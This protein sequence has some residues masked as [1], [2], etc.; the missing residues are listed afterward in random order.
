[1]TNMFAYP[2]FSWSGISST[3]RLEEAMFYFR[4]ASPV[5]ASPQPL[6]GHCGQNSALGS[7]VQTHEKGSNHYRMSKHASVHMETNKPAKTRLEVSNSD[8][9]VD[10]SSRNEVAATAKRSEPRMRG[11]VAHGKDDETERPLEDRRRRNKLLEQV[12]VKDKL[13]QSKLLEDTVKNEEQDNNMNDTSLSPTTYNASPRK[14]SQHQRKLVPN[15]RHLKNW[16]S[17]RI[18]KRSERT[19]G[20]KGGQ[21]GSDDQSSPIRTRLRTG[22]ENHSHAGESE[23]GQSEQGKRCHTQRL[24]SHD[25]M[26]GRYGSDVIQRGVLAS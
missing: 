11:S 18:P 10:S 24:R 6:K 15:G 17:F 22:S 19:A 16:G 21:E 20:G 9:D 12:S 3:R 8:G 23:H 14:T 7:T 5:P 25:P 2:F 1:M 26:T 4:T 13:R